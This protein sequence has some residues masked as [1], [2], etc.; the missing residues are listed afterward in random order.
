MKKTIFLSVSTLFIAT[1]L[2]SQTKVAS[3]SCGK[4]GTDKY[5]HLEFW[6]KDG[7]RSEAKYTYGKDQREVKLQYL[8]IEKVN[9]NVCFKVQFINNYILHIIPK[10]LQLQVFDSNGKYNKVFSWEY[11]GPVNGIGTYC[12]VC[13]E[14][15]D[16]AMKLVLSSY[17]K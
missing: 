5:E 11:E 12:D 15:E 6:T 4:A 8:G 7:K 3:Y 1:T 2:I 17:L 9:G 13:A 10:G 14:D 16:D